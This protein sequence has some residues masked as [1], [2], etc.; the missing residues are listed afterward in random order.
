MSTKYETENPFKLVEIELD[1][2]QKTQW[3]QV[4]A[5]L[6]WQ[7]GW[8]HHIMVTMLNPRNDDT[9]LYWTRDIKTLATD[10]FRIAANPDYYF[11]LTLQERIF[12]VC[13]EIA[14]G[15]LFHCDALYKAFMDGYVTL[16]GKQLP[17][18]KEIAGKAVDYPIND[19]L[20]KA[21]IGAFNKS[22]LHD[23][24][25]G[26]ENDAWVE[27]Y[28]RLHNQKPPPPP[29]GGGGKS[30]PG[31]DEDDQPGKAPSAGQPDND[32]DNDND[33]TQQG[34][35]PMLGGT[36]QDDHLPPGALGNGMTPEQAATKNQQRGEMWRNAIETASK[37]LEAAMARG[38]GSAGMK[39]FFEKFLE[40]TVT[41]TDE[42]EGTFAKKIGSGSYNY[43]RPDR[44][45]ITRD[46]Y[47]PS[48]SGHGC[49]TLVIASDTS[50][51]IFGVPHLIE[52]FFAEMAELMS[53]YK[54]V[55]TIVLWI[56]AEVKRAVYLD[57][58]YDLQREW[59]NG[60]E[61]GGGTAFEPA[62]KWVED[63][64]IEDI[65][66]MVYLTDLEGSFPPE[67]PYY[68]VIWL[69]INHELKGPFG[70]TINIPK[71]GTA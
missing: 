13:H 40:P 39:K 1:H 22:W 49:R 26:T 59:E 42:I 18:D 48:R 50:G 36:L 17:Y 29:S 51:S 44:R 16:G 58:V 8:F 21:K 62:F 31:D 46:I 33:D 24:K 63:N 6:H 61:G 57:D 65:D 41:W 25:I 56:D 32:N 66:A 9:M 11:S 28:G 34:N 47:A 55:R 14:H 5:G 67:A 38:Q 53:V 20:I 3:T 52:R 70:D 68:P 15:M 71:D 19:M 45:L 43:R 64:E 23:T 54:P 60:A 4:K 12:A 35:S 37:M 7:A 27:V 10:G 69:T 2:K 30:Q